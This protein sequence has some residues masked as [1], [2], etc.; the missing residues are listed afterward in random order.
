MLNVQII[1]CAPDTSL[2][3]VASYFPSLDNAI[4][5]SNTNKINIL[6]LSLLHPLISQNKFGPLHFSLFTI[7]PIHDIELDLYISFF[8]LKSTI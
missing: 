5:S 8:S 1:D 7:S 2:I 3:Q 6:V 4:S